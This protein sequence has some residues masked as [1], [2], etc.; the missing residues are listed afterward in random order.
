MWSRDPIRSVPGM[1]TP[2][3]TPTNEGAELALNAET[4]DDLDPRTTQ[5]R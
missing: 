3:A 5:L 1:T 2:D 4:L